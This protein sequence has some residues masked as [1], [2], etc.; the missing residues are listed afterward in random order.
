MILITISHFFMKFLVWEMTQTIRMR[1][2][3]VNV[4]IFSAARTTTNS[5]DV[6]G[7]ITTGM[8]NDVEAKILHLPGRCNVICILKFLKNI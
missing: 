2:H 6:N 1:V 5:A 3:P 4:P 8:T 7:V